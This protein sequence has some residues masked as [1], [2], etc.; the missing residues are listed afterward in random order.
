MIAV[1]ITLTA[2]SDAFR[3]EFLTYFEVGPKNMQPGQD[4]VIRIKNTGL[5]QANNAIVVLAINSTVTN[6]V[7]RC[8]EGHVSSLDSSTIIAKFERMSPGMECQVHV[9]VKEVAALDV[10][11]SADGRMTT[12]VKNSFSPVGW[13]V[14]SLFGLFL[15]MVMV[16]F[17]VKK[18]QPE[19]MWYWIDFKLH[20]GKFKPS[21]NADKVDK[22]VEEN[23]SIKLGKVDASILERVYDGDKTIRRLIK[24][25]GLSLSQIKYRVGNLRY[26]ELIVTDKIEIEETLQRF[27]K[28]EFDKQ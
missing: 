4:N 22:V 7:D 2:G 5:I 13:L 19:K 15:E 24:E 8:A 27:L 10:S 16:Y 3:A 12:W 1:I 21:K 20:E 18:M 26:F 25:S 14:I 17:I 11:I 28:E 23:Y 6:Y 9:G